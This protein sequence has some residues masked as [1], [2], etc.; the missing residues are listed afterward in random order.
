MGTTRKKTHQQY[1]DELYVI[2]PNIEAVEQY[3]N[4]NTKI[5]HR[6]KI[7]GYEWH[8]K[9]LHTLHRRGCPKCSNHIP[10]TLES[11]K[12]V[13]GC[14]N[15]NIIII[16]DNYINNKTPILVQ[17]KNDHHIWKATPNS[18]LRGS[19]CPVCANK[20]IGDAPDYK[21]SI[22]ASTHR[23]YFSQFLS[24]EQ[25]KSYTPHSC[26]KVYAI[27]PDCGNRKYI[28]IEQLLNQGLG[29]I[30]GD[31]QSY[32][33]KFV[34]NV[35]RQLNIN[36]KPEY[37]PLWNEKVR[38]DDY[39]L[40]YNIII[41]NHGLQ[42]YQ[43]ASSFTRHTLFDE[44]RNDNL[45]QQ[46]ALEHGVQYYV[47]LDCRESSAEWL[48]QS[49]MRSVLPQLLDFREED[50]NWQQADEYAICNLVKV[51]A[52][53]FNEG[54]TVT[55]IANELQV[56][57]PTV[58]RWLKRAKQFGWCQYTPKSITRAVYCIE[59]NESFPSIAAASRELHIWA[60]S[61]INCLKG[62]WQHTISSSTKEKL[63]WLYVEDAISL[64]YINNTK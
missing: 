30:C 62:R 51:S 17:C 21:N 12:N 18:L 53:L 47:V 38:Y 16:D 22:W 5:L 7:D 29:C 26:K 44:Q 27:C 57:K 48:K 58:A 8:V 23:E 55:D 4:S 32:P 25:M 1:V 61:I 45:K 24:E 33:N 63:H 56:A 46:L 40:D 52:E 42:H 49:I 3:V 60:T 39:L 11:F 50:I 6:C 14:V 20:I 43:E 64:G 41:E 36:V 13:L 10:H 9:P 28:V 15:A 54:K 19:T 59:L 31:G 37:T 34:Y 35:L 2:N